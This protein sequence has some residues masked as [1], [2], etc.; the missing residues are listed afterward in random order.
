MLKKE[1]EIQDHILTQN[2]SILSQVS[3][4]LI[5]TNRLKR[6][7]LV[8]TLSAILTTTAFGSTIG[9]VWA[10]VSGANFV[11]VLGWTTASLVFFLSYLLV[12]FGSAAERANYAVCL[13][14]G[15]VQALV[16][17]VHLQP[18]PSGSVLVVLLAV[19][20]LVGMVDF[21]GILRYLLN[22]F[23]A[24]LMSGLY[25]MD[26]LSRLSA[27]NPHPNIF[28]WSGI[29]Y[30]LVSYLVIIPIIAVFVRQ[31]KQTTQLT[32]AQAAKLSE[33][34]QTLTSTTNFGATIS[35]DLVGITAWL[36]TTSQ[37]QASSGRHLMHVITE[38]TINIEELNATA[39]QIDSATHL[40]AQVIE[41]A[42]LLANEVKE[43]SELA[44]LMGIQGKQAVTETNQSV[45]YLHHRINLLGQHLSQLTT[46]T[47]RVGGMI[48]LIDYIAHETHLLAIN[49]SIEAAGTVEKTANSQAERF[50]VIA[51]EIRNLS[52]RSQETAEKMRKAIEEMQN[53][54]K[55]SLM[56]VEEG[57]IETLNTSSRSLVAG[58]VIEKLHEVTTNSTDRADHI[59]EAANQVSVR[60]KEIYFAI[61]HQHNASRQILATMHHIVTISE[62]TVN[63]VSQFSDTANQIN[64]QV[65]KLNVLLAKSNQ[66]MQPAVLV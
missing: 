44:V 24:L 45:K 20:V 16:L 3:I 29:A 47:E 9:A 22:L 37:Q 55:A 58:E 63:S 50:G 23:T 11:S 13:Q 64:Q 62:E 18:N 42:V 34:V 46:E 10:V 32:I 17:I 15:G 56:A 38:A 61:N 31:Q 25:I 35:Q 33:L 1:P 48:E 5:Q 14:V 43:S 7:E 21:K 40:A 59:L 2:T 36:N 8:K 51:Q 28:D 65:D 19:P 57:K 4:D 60:F 27:P 26:E 54:M 66:V 52:K 6:L 12:R 41:Q 30:L 49:A 53:S 39:S